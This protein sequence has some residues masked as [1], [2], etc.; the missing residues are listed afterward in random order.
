[1]IVVPGYLTVAEFSKRTIM[2]QAQ[3]ARIETR[4]PG[5]LDMQLESS[6][7]WI[8]AR[9]AKR[10]RVPFRGH[11]PEQV[12]SWVA[13]MVTLR[14]YLSHGINASDQQLALVT[15]DAEKAEA[16]VREAAN[17]EI[18]LIDLPASDEIGTSAV[19]EGSP[20]FYS[21]TSPYVSLDVQRARGRADDQRKRGS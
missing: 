11:V 5:W 2:P 15:S 21:E 4:D 20:R 13:R 8:D 16:E 1:M 17:G 19:T 14:A 3:I 12:R 10:Y 6:S 9:L 7:R 18:G